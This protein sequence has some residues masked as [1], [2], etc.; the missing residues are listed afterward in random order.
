PYGPWLTARVRDDVVA[1]CE[2]AARTGFEPL[3]TEIRHRIGKVLAAAGLDP[4]S[5]DVAFRS[6]GLRL[7]VVLSGPT[8][9]RPVQQALGV[10][11]LDAVRSSRRNY[12]EVDVTYEPA[13]SPIG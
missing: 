12:G 2:Q 10:R 8:V 7:T 5:I 9:E 3:R 13:D 1:T 4:T 11:V 6:D